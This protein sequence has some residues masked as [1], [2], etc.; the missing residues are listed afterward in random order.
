MSSGGRAEM[1]ESI[2]APFTGCFFAI[3][4][5]QSIAKLSSNRLLS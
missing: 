5:T 4:P 3:H 1:Q 2:K